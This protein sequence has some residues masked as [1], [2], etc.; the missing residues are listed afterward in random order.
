MSGTN[1]SRPARAFEAD[2]RIP[3]L[4]PWG[5]DTARAVR[6]GFPLAADRFTRYEIHPVCED[7]HTGLVQRCASRDAS[8]RMAFASKGRAFWRL[9]GW[10]SGRPAVAIGDFF[11]FADASQVYQLITGAAAPAE[12]APAA[13]VLRA[14]P[15]GVPTV[16]Q[17]PPPVTITRAE[18]RAI[19]FAPRY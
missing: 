6:T 14:V 3:N 1:N 13:P 10:A 4:R 18:T 7:G 15:Q 8:L 11:S 12:D 5:R 16:E 9:F 2:L 17:R 19:G